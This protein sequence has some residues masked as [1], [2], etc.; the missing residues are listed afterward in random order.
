MVP[1]LLGSIPPSLRWARTLLGL[2]AGVLSLALVPAAASAFSSGTAGPKSPNYDAKRSAER[3]RRSRPGGMS[4]V[5]RLTSAVLLVPGAGYYGAQSSTLVR[6][7]Q[8]RLAEVGAGLGAVDGRYGPLTEQAVARFQ[9]AHGL[10]VDGIAGPV[11]L[12]ALTA[13]TPT[14]YPG[15]GYQQAAGSGAVRGLQHRLAALGFAP[16][17]I[18]GRDGPLT[19][20]AVERFQGAR[21]LHVDGIVGVHTWN[22]L[23]AVG[24]HPG[25]SRRPRKRPVVNGQPVPKAVQQHRRAPAL[26]VTLVL[27]GLAALGLATMSLSYARARARVRRARAN[28]R[29]RAL[30]I[31]PVASPPGSLVSEHEERQR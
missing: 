30:R 8:L 21:G 17:P 16:G 26:P 18:D 10:V 28:V 29:L 14:L 27:L 6:A 3:V 7:L 1:N 24:R 22:A 9:A 15:A 31:D 20:R 4:G 2:A 19:T 23:G 12:A 25:A 11:T 13:P 5:R